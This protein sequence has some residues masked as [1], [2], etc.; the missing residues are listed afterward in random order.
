MEGENT[1]FENKMKIEYDYI[2]EQEEEGK[3]E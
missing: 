1:N 3:G 2:A